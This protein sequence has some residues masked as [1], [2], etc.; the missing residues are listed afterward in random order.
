MRLLFVAVIILIAAG[1]YFNKM[2]QKKSSDEVIKEI[3]PVTGSIKTIISCTGTVLP[4]NRLEV[5]PPVSGRVESIL[6]REGDK[7]KEGQVLAWMSSTE[8]AALLDAAR[9]KGEEALKYWQETYKPI[10]LPA[11]IDGE[12]IVATTQPGQTVT[13]TDAVVVLSDQLIIRA[14]IDET[15]IG[16]IA[17]NQKATVTLDAYS[18]TKIKSTVEHIYY[19]SQTVNNV[20]VYLVDLIPEEIP[21]FFRSGMNASVDFITQDKENILT[22]PVEAVIKDGKGDFVLVKQPRGKEPVKR[23][24]SLGISDDKNVEVLSGV[25]EKD[26]IVLK[27]KKYSLPTSSANGK[28][29]FLPSRRR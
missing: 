22:V 8:R 27:A 16:K 6:V 1:I 24:V 26:A 10:S 28:N 17:L 25:S 3:S 20:T 15:D 7:V 11:S 4:K 13:V 9:A 2:N 19:E 14:Q 5:K 21:S 23:Q 12:V 18:D 29:P